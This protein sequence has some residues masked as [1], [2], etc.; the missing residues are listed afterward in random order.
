MN[1]YLSQEEVD[2][3]LRGISEGEVAT[4]QDSGPEPEGVRPY[5]LTNP[6]RIIRG[7]MPTL[8]ILNQ[9]LAR[10][11]RAE[12]SSALRRL[13]DVNAQSVEM[14]K[15]GEFLKT[16]P[17]PT[18]MHIFRMP[19]LRGGALLVIESRLV[20]AL[21]DSFFGGSGSAQV[22][23]EGRDFTPIEMH[24]IQRV[25]HLVFS[26][27]EK[28]WAPVVPIRITLER[29]E[30]NPQFASIV[31][32]SDIVVVVPLEVEMDEARG[33]MTLCIPYSTL[34]P[35]RAKLHA[36]FQT[37]R[38]EIDQGWQRHIIR[39]LKDVE[40]ELSVELGTTELTL[41]ALLSLQAGDILRLDQDCDSDLLVRVEGVPKFKGLPR[42]VKQK[43][44]VEIT[45]VLKPPVEEED[46]EHLAATP[47]ESLDA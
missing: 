28:A 6:E 17:V 4:E 42:V 21:I 33:F 27:M 15:F 44:A 31:P 40:V 30:V 39:F 9:K 34:E 12:L 14:L 19:P 45:Q 24:M 41:Q 18:S 35:V 10:L 36:G 29:S 16:L 13:V 20:F 22:K 7:R 38:L 43:K 46:S 26:Q 47:A 11:L 8:E 1:Q 25:V 3:L 2:A 5:D 37:E 23:I 32:A